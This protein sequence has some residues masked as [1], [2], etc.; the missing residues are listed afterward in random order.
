[1]RHTTQDHYDFNWQDD[2]KAAEPAS[3]TAPS[4]PADVAV[5]LLLDHVLVDGLLSREEVGA[6]GT[7][8]V[9][10]TPDTAWS[11]AVLEHWKAAVRRGRGSD[12]SSRFWREQYESWTYWI[13]KEREQTKG[14]V[15][16][17]A[18]V[19][20]RAVAAG[21]HCLGVAHDLA[22][23]PPDL[24]DAADHT[25]TLPFLSPGTWPLSP[26]PCAGP[27]RPKLCP[28]PKPPC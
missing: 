26:T 18:D 28:T 16:E 5:A 25:L 3:S 24:V 21:S 8:S 6:D 17:A 11:E 4:D 9:V 13:T 12:G 1:M 20:S 2:D 10:I 14:E 15:A 19:F 22:V 23:L 27:S 7:V